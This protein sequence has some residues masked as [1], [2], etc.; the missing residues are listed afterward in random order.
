MAMQVKYATV[1]LGSNLIY[2][3][4]GKREDHKGFGP[5]VEFVE[6]IKIDPEMM[7]IVVFMHDGSVSHHFGC[8]CVVCSEDNP[9]VI[10]PEKII[11]PKIEIAS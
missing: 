7:S 6:D 5:D 10:I 2:Y 4:I 1:V 8:P 11:T 9:D 3:R